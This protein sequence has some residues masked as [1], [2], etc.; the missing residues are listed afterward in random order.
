M[1]VIL[2]AILLL[3]LGVT[4]LAITILV[5]KD[6]KF[7]DGEIAH[8]KALRQQGIVCAKEEELRLWRKRNPKAAAAGQRP[9]ACPEGGCDGCAF[10]ETK[11]SPC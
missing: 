6:G 11:S 7:P 9:N 2:L 4:G 8:N 5:K 3:A 1:K 10:F